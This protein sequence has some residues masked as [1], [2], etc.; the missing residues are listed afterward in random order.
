MQ[1][2]GFCTVEP[3]NMSYFKEIFSIVL[4]MLLVQ[5]NTGIYKCISIKISGD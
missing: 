2:R 5:W 1:N 3:V 4:L